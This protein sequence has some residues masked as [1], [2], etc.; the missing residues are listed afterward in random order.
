M[1]TNPT[2]LYFSGTGN[3]LAAA[4][5]MARRL[6]GSSIR[7]LYDADSETMPAGRLL[8]LVFPVHF[9][10]A[11]PAVLSKVEELVPADAALFAIATSGGEAGDALGQVADALKK[12]GSELI[13]SAHVPMADN[14]VALRT[15]EERR[16]SNVA[17]ASGILDRLASDITT[18]GTSSGPRHPLGWRLAGTLTRIGMM[19]VYGYDRKRIDSAACT[20]CGACSRACP[21]GNIALADRTAHIGEKCVHCFGCLHACPASAIRFGRLRVTPETRY[22]PPVLD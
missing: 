13:A 19:A 1:V 4:R 22:V 18:G 3:S 5:A 6:P 9:M 2:I 21:V 15:S 8:G 7:P 11:P 16:R 12:R 17:A 20:G 10:Q 14:S